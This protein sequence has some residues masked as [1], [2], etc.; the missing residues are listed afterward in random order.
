MY[1]GEW[2]K[3]NFHGKGVLNKKE[4]GYSFA[5]SFINGKEEGYFNIVSN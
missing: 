1:D 4:E 3:D 5:G 2:E